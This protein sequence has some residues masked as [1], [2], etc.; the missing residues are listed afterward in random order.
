MRVLVVYATVEGQ[1]RKIAEHLVSRLKLLGC[2][3]ELHDAESGAGPRPGGF[4]AVIVAAP[5]HMAKFADAAQ[6]WVEA[7]SV[8]LNAL[9]SAFVSVSL[10]AASKFEDEH[11]AIAEIT[12]TF[13]TGASW[14]PRLVHHA[15]GAL[16][17]TQYDFIRRFLMKHIAE[18]EGGSTDTSRDHEYTDWARLDALAAE[19]VGSARVAA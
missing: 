17:Y 9:P 6:T 7:N 11:A 3:A 14:K 15:A 10:A 4:D 5:V 2:T 12:E 13:L 16:R 8:Q 1:T 18:K 19:L